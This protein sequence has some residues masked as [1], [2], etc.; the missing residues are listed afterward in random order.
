MKKWNKYSVYRVAPKLSNSLFSLILL[1]L[2]LLLSLSSSR[3]YPLD[4]QRNTD[5]KSHFIFFSLTHSAAQSFTKSF[6]NIQ[7]IDH[8]YGIV[9]LLCTCVYVY[10]CVCEREREGEREGVWYSL[11]TYSHSEYTRFKV[12]FHK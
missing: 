6:F 12:S 8:Q 1:L 3:T 7:P 4:I 2:Q 5:P 11:N 9:F 10:V